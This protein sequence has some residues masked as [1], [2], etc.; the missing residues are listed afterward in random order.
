MPNKIA[1]NKAKIV[2]NEFTD[3]LEALNLIAKRRRCSLSDIMREA[4]LMYVE[5][6]QDTV[7]LQRKLDEER[8]PKKVQKKKS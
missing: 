2:Y 1:E 4:A 3:T 8:A 5:K 7:E 6:H